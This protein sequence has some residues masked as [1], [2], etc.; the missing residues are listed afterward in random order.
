MDSELESYQQTA[1]CSAQN[2]M[3][4]VN[5][6]LTL[7]ELRAGRVGLA[8]EPFDLRRLL[9]SLASSF[10]QSAH[11]K[12]LEFVLE[13][14]EPLPDSV[15][16]DP[17]KLRQ[18]MECL[19]DNAIKFTKSGFIRVRAGGV[20]AEDGTVQMLIE[21]IDS[22]IGFTRLKEPVL[23]QRFF[24]V[25]GSM[26]RE[27]GGLGIGLAICAQLIELQGGRLSHRSEPGRG[28]CFALNVPLL[29]LAHQV[30]QQSS[31]RGWKV[32]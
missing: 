17:N 1:A 27:Y 7:T 3:S 19:L 30:R 16:G 23:Y 10:A 18:C 22:G 31:S 8:S 2:M 5:G 4:M 29:T 6:I 21:V 25:D 28:S 13:L 14:D 20:T 24:Q 11:A 26:T 9:Q 15:Q 12:G 32:L